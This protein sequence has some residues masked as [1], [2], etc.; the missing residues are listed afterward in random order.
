MIFKLA[1]IVSRIQSLLK[2][3]FTTMNKTYLDK[4]LNGNIFLAK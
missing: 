2:Q 4:S 3:E 1:K